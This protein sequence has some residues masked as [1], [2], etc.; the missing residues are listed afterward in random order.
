MK[1]RKYKSLCYEV[2][3]KA[4]AG[5]PEAINAV[6]HRLHQSPVLLSRAYQR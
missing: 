2:I 3:E 5:E 4:V 6:L 1:N